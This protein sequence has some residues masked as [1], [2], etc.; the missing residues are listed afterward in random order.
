MQ[1]NYK[2]FDNQISLLSCKKTIVNEWPLDFTAG[3][4]IRP[5]TGTEVSG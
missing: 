1:N 5:R 4:Y 2:H 3:Q